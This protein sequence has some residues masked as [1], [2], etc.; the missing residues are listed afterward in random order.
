MQTEKSWK[1]I[2]SPG[3]EDSEMKEERRKALRVLPLQHMES[4]LHRDQWK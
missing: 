3:E 2:L 4:D 1:K